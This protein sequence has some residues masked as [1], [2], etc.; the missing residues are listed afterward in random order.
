MT[1]VILGVYIIHRM[2]DTLL[3]HAVIA[4]DLGAMFIVQVRLP[5]GFAIKDLIYSLGRNCSLAASHNK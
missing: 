5:N 2:C 1:L 4:V 3:M